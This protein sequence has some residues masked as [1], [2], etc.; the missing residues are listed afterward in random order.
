MWRWVS[1]ESGRER[2]RHRGIGKGPP[3]LTR[4][5]SGNAVVGLHL[6]ARPPYPHTP[7]CERLCKLIRICC[8]QL[9]RQYTTT[10]STLN[11]STTRALA[12]VCFAFVA[13]GYSLGGLR[14]QAVARSLRSV[15]Q[16]ER[17]LVLVAFDAPV[18]SARALCFERTSGAGGGPIRVHGHAFLDTRE[19]PDCPFARQ[20]TDIRQRGE[21]S[22]NPACQRAPEL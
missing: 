7:Q 10:R 22:E 16:V 8:G 14:G 6:L 17:A 13:S 21:C 12:S 9:V 19:A 3:L 20:N 4:R 5:R 1:P 18:L 15:L 2:S 11:R